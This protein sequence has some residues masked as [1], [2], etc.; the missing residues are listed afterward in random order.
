VY[1]EVTYAQPA[2]IIS[3]IKQLDKE[4]AEALAMLEQLLKN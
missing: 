4:R 2:T 1:D 3:D